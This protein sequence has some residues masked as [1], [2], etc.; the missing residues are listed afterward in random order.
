[1]P[2]RH[3]YLCPSHTCHLLTPH[4]FPE[5][6]RIPVPKGLPLQSPSIAR[7]PSRSMCSH[8][9]HPPP[10]HHSPLLPPQTVIGREPDLPLSN[11]H[12]LC[13]RLSRFPRPLVFQ[14]LGTYSSLALCPVLSLLPSLFSINSITHHFPRICQHPKRPLPCRPHNW[15]K[16]SHALP[17]LPAPGV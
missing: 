14:P 11:Q 1:M 3:L 13:L 9:Q 10:S 6:Q 12:L 4:H 15:Q 16:C 7:M 5:S 8:P 17:A 2:S